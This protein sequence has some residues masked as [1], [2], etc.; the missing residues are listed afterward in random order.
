MLFSSPHAP[1]GYCPSETARSAS[2][3]TD[4]RKDILRSETIYIKPYKPPAEKDGKRRTVCDRDKK[5]AS[6]VGIGSVERC[7]YGFCGFCGKVRSAL[8]E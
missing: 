3:H 7:E 6:Q 5:P 1:A 4:C 8:Q 2:S